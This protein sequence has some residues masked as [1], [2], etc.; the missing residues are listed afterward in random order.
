MYPTTGYTP[1]LRKYC[2]RCGREHG[3]QLY[4]LCE[5]CRLKDWVIEQHRQRDEE[6]ILADAE[7]IVFERE[8][9]LSDDPDEERDR[10][11]EISFARHGY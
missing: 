11:S 5:I 7:A 9:L 6:L 10:Q 8:Q 4:Y 3:D 1:P 2:I